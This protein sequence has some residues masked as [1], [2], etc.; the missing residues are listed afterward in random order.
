MALCLN[1][2]H[3]PTWCHPVVKYS[4]LLPSPLPSPRS[5]SHSHF[6]YSTLSPPHLGRSLFS[7][8]GLTVTCLDRLQSPSGTDSAGF[9][10]IT[11]P[12]TMV[13]PWQMI[14]NQYV[15]LRF[16]NNTNRGWRMARGLRAFV[17]LA[18]DPGWVPN[19]NI[20]AHNSSF[21]GSNALF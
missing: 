14:S 7:V 2:I 12:S 1:N 20:A 15:H 19:T 10:A 13:C 6:F 3:S 21:R 8:I 18:E 16:K 5:G 11:E 4:Q 17:V 9:A